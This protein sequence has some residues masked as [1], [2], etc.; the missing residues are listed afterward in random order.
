MINEVINATDKPITQPT[1]TETNLSK[2]EVMLPGCSINIINK[3]TNARRTTCIKLNNLQMAVV[4]IMP[5]K[6]F[7][8]YSIL[9][10]KTV[11]PESDPMKLEETLSR[12]NFTANF[13]PSGGMTKI[14]D[15]NAQ[16]NSFCGK[17]IIKE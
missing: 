2:G 5:N 9:I 17:L 12:L 1:K 14:M 13:L 15:S 16:K 8:I 4:S 6:T 10:K 11:K 7:K 3:A